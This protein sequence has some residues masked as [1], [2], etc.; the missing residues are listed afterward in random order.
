[1]KLMGM[2]YTLKK[3]MFSPKEKTCREDFDDETWAYSLDGVVGVTFRCIRESIPFF[4]RAGGGSIVNIASMYGVVAPDH[5]IYGDTG[6]NS[7]VTYGA[8]KAGVALYKCGHLGIGNVV[9]FWFTGAVAHI[10]QLKQ[11]F[12]LL[13]KAYVGHAAGFVGRVFA[14]LRFVLYILLA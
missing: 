14:A 2:N 4:K 9:A 3:P 12:F 8:G 5:S 6:N 11:L 13:R 7:P 10:Q 1:M